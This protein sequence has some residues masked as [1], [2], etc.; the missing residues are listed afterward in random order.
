MASRIKSSGLNMFGEN[1]PDEDSHSPLAERVR[2][3]ELEDFV[4][5]EKLTGK[6]GII[7]KFIE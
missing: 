1:A 2:P 3:K 4:G 5:Q 6:N 7:R